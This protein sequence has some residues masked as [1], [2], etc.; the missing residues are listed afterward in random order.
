MY[1]FNG[2]EINAVS[3]NRKPL[4]A[5]YYEHSHGEYSPSLDSMQRR[6]SSQ[7]GDSNTTRDDY[8]R[9]TENGRKLAVCHKNLVWCLTSVIT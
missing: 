3:E 2:S 1:K 6:V 5:F 9:E 4:I 8:Q 7:L